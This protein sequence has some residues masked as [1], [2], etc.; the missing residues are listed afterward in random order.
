MFCSLCLF[1]CLFGASVCVHSQG[2]ALKSKET[3]VPETLLLSV[4]RL[5]YV[6]MYRLQLAFLAYFYFLQDSLSLTCKC[7]RGGTETR[8]SPPGTHMAGGGAHHCHGDGHT[9]T[10]E[11]RWLVLDWNC[12][13]V[14]G[15]RSGWRQLVAVCAVS[16]WS[17]GHRVHMP[18]LKE[19]EREGRAVGE[20]GERWERG[21]S[22]GREG[23]VRGE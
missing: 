3:S 15:R 10:R 9:Q 20:R 6:R 22:G 13:F 23:R 21:E 14:R 8:P 1:V 2:A 16:D 11:G 19:V 12:L 4:R 17:A 7:H 18:C 5:C